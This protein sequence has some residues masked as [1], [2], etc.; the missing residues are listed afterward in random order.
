MK[1][2]LRPGLALFGLALV[3]GGWTQAQVLHDP[4]NYTVE[5]PLAGLSLSGSS[6]WTALNTGTAPVIAAGSLEVAGL[7]S[8]SGN[9]VSFPGGNFQEAVL[10]FP[11]ITSGSIYYSFAL[12][13]TSLPTDETF[14]FALVTGTTTYGTALWI[15]PSGSGYQIGVTQRSFDSVKSYDSTVYNLNTTQ[16]IVGRHDYVTGTTNDVSSLWIN[17]ASASFGAAEAPAALL[18]STGS[19][20]RG[21]TDHFLLRGGTGSPAGSFDELRI[22]TTWASVTPAAVPEPSSSVLLLG[23]AATVLVLLRRRST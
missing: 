20:D 5:Q 12:R 17:P 22:G 3:F 4:F 16:F 11:T 7:A 9:S 14:T 19:T 21:F 1:P 13:L 8:S 18:M 23:C 2:R 6:A 10:S 15:R